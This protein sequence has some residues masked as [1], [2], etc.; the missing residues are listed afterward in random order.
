MNGLLNFIDVVEDVE[1]AVTTSNATVDKHMRYDSANNKI[2]S[3]DLNCDKEIYVVVTINFADGGKTV[4]KKRVVIVQ[5]LF[6]SMVDGATFNVSSNPVG[7][8]L[9]TNDSLYTNK[10]YRVNKNGDKTYLNIQD[11][12]E[13][14]PVNVPTNTFAV[15]SQYSNVVKI[16]Y[17]EEEPFLSLVGAS[18]GSTTKQVTVLYN[19]CV[20]TNNGYYYLQYEFDILLIQA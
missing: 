16:S 15:A 7:L 2:Y 8:N 3:Y 11:Y 9:T 19:Y 6:M 13:Y 17:H 1:G 10:I 5:N 14:D 18:L 20:T 4:I 12:I